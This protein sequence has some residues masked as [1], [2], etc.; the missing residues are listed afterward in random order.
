MRRLFILLSMLFAIS[1]GIAQVFINPAFERTGLEVIHPHIDEVEITEDSV[2]IY[3][4]INFHEEQ[5][6]Y[7]THNMYLEDI[8]NGKKYYILSCKG[9][10]FDSEKEYNIYNGL[11]HF[12]LRF[13]PL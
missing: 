2:T 4:S 1:N 5:F 9:I 13:P 7:I 8:E 3:C 12:I 6:Y 10:S 11:H